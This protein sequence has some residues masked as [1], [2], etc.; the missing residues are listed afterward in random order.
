[1]ENFLENECYC[2]MVRITSLLAYFDFE[3]K[4]LEQI[5]FHNCKLLYKFG[6][7]SDWFSIYFKLYDIELALRGRIIKGER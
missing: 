3:L 7:D 5:K 6:T 2:Q 1:M 4:P